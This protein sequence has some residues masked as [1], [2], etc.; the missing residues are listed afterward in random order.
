M[1]LFLYSLAVTVAYTLI[2]LAEPS[3][4]SVLVGPYVLAMICP[5]CWRRRPSTRTPQRP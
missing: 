2:A 3:V 4:A 5:A 1:A